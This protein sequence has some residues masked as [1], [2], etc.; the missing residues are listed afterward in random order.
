ML[1]NYY[2]HFLYTPT[3]NIEEV[4]ISSLETDKKQNVS[5]DIHHANLIIQIEIS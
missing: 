2:K 3:F 4:R 1:L 5:T